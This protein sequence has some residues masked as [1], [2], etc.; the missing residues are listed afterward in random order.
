MY[1]FDM[2]S[3]LI[4]EY[5]YVSSKTAVAM[6]AVSPVTIS[7][8]YVNAIQATLPFRL[9]FC[10]YFSTTQRVLHVNNSEYIPNVK[11]DPAKVPFQV[12]SMEHRTKYVNNLRC[13]D[14]QTE[15][16]FWTLPDRRPV[17]LI[18]S[19]D[20]SSWTQF[21]LRRAGPCKQTWRGSLETDFLKQHECH[22]KLPSDF[23]FRPKHRLSW[24]RFFVIFFGLSRKILQ[25]LK[26]YHNHS[27]Y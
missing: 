5:I 1:C 15:S 16:E 13:E 27:T 23:E 21:R 6:C 9:K 18:L 8:H 26:Y 19:C 3:I 25:H 2:G 11:L 20:K 22:C 24:L 12:H 4:S 10:T 7:F 17:P 14:W